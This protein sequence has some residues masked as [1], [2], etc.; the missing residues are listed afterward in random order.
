MSEVSAER[1]LGAWVR[2]ARIKRGWSQ[3]EL[4]N[5]LASYAIKL[6]PSGITRLEKGQRPIRLDEAAAIARV[7]NT[8]IEEMVSPPDNLLFE[9]AETARQWLASTKAAEGYGQQ[10]A[11][12]IKKYGS[13]QDLMQPDLPEDVRDA[14]NEIWH[15]L[16]W[17]TN[18]LSRVAEHHLDQ[19][20]KGGDTS[21]C[22]PVEKG[23]FTL[24]REGKDYYL[25]LRPR[26][27]AGERHGHALKTGPYA[28]R[29]A[30]LRKYVSLARKNE[31]GSVTLEDRTG[32]ADD[33]L[34]ARQ[35]LVR[36]VRALYEQSMAPADIAKHLDETEEA[37]E[38]MIY[39][40]DENPHLYDERGE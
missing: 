28:S 12:L 38:Q 18:Y 2:D 26:G 30:A 32:P 5:E 7:F 16:E 37:V 31:D 20:A 19:R 27:T 9:A 17:M 1:R 34:R 29:H 24:T 39:E 33:A 36:R 11:E 25:T 35:Q 23:A 40:F 14:R 22:F 6:D 8:T 15:A 21:P 4:A 3:R 13:M 10:F